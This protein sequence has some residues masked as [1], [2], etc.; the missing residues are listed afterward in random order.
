MRE[1]RIAGCV[2]QEFTNEGKL[3]GQKF[4]GE[5]CEHEPFTL[6]SRSQLDD[7]KWQLQREVYKI[8]DCEDTVNILYDAID[9]RVNLMN[10]RNC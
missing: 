6:I 2:V 5:E 9:E 4:I 10:T 3:V 8:I 7:L 1:K